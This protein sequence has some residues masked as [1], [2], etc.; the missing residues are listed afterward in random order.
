MAARA[1]DQDLTNFD[2][3]VLAL[4]VLSIV[5]IAMAIAPLSAAVHNAVSYRPVL[6]PG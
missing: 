1:G 5:N 6:R 3:F 4:S 2:V